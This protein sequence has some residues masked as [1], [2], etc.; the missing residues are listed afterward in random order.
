MSS[1]TDGWSCD[2]NVLCSGFWWA[3]AA[4]CCWLLL[5]AACCC[6]LLLAAA[7]CCWLPLAAA[8]CCC[9]L[10]AAAVC[11]QLAAVCCCLLARGGASSSSVFSLEGISLQ[12]WL[13]RLIAQS[14]LPCAPS[15]IGKFDLRGIR[16]IP[17]DDLNHDYPRH[18]LM[19]ETELTK[20]PHV[21]DE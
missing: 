17:W 16:N 10:L 13:A 11:W 21:F 15:C 8:G 2:H 4:G 3:S 7:G 6:L 9:L 18:G 5:S 20:S 19:G 12:A 1:D 14:S